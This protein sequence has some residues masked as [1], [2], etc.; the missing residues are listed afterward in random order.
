MS[1]PEPPSVESA[2]PDDAPHTRRAGIVAV[3]YWLVA[4]AIY[5]TLG[6]L[7]PWLFLL[8]FW[9]SFIFVAIVTALQPVVTRRLA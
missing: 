7:V 4:G 6:L 3:V 1:T 8:G 5:V 2:S 9:Q